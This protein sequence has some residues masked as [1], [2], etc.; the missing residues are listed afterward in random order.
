M[1][2]RGLFSSQFWRLKVQDLVAPS[3]P[4]L[5]KVPFVALQHGKEAKRETATGRG[6]QAHGVDLLYNN[7]REN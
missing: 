2:K 3:V 4:P 1:K 6:G 7:Y 5:M